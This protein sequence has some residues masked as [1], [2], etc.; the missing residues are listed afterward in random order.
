MWEDL[1][2]GAPV[3][4][5]KNSVHRD[6]RFSCIYANVCWRHFIMKWGGRKEKDKQASQVSQNR[7]I[8]PYRVN[9]SYPFNKLYQHIGEKMMCYKEIGIPRKVKR[10]ELLQEIQAAVITIST[11]QW[12]ASGRSWET[13]SQTQAESETDNIIQF[14]LQHHWS[15][16]SL[17]VLYCYEISV[18]RSFPNC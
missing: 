13:I 12:Q 17:F 9:D 7:F 16:V 14:N 10:M 4:I 6:D 15:C 3:P 11:I 18:A 5:E 1:N 2:F 8:C